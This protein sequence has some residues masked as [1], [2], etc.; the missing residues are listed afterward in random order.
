[1]TLKKGDINY[2]YGIVEDILLIKIFP[3]FRTTG[4]KR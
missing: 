3:A 2:S 4:G 1:M